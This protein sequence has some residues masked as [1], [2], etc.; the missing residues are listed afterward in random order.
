MPQNW[1][2]YTFEMSESFDNAEG[3]S[4]I[5][6][7][8]T[9]GDETIK[10]ARVVYWDAVGQYFVEVFVDEVP[11][12]VMEDLIQTARQKIKVR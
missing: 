7:S 5:D 4:A 6:L 3:W 1:S 8:L 10:A 11:A 2:G 12:P 9:R